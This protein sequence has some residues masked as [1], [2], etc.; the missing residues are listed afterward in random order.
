[1]SL[2]VV[3]VLLAAVVVGYLLLPLPWRRPIVPTAPGEVRFPPGFLWGAATSDH[4][5]EHSQA[6]DW[7]AFEQD[8]RA[9]GRQD[10]SAPGRPNRGHVAGVA[11]VHPDVLHKKADWD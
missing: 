8:A 2:V 10:P 9:A 11:D 1:M 3:V 7:T 5:I 6:D 4:Q